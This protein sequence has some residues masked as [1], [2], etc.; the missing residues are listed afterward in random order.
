MAE[1]NKTIGNAC[2]GCFCMDKSRHTCVRYF[3]GNTNTSQAVIK[4]QFCKL[5]CLNEEEQF[6]EVVFAKDRIKLDVPIQIAVFILNLAKLRMLQFHYDWLD[7]LVSREDY[8]LLEMD[9]DSSYMALS[10][11]TFEEAV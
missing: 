10:K 1:T 11:P 6:Y 7:R 2:Y 4:P 8:M 3:K 9:T 5:T